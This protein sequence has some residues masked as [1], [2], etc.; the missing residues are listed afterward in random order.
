MGPIQPASLLQ[1]T[2]Y[3]MKSFVVVSCLIAQA[4][5][6]CFTPSNFDCRRVSGTFPD[7]RDCG[8][9]FVQCPN[10]Q[11]GSTGAA[12][13]CPPGQWFDPIV[14]NCN[15]GRP[16]CSAIRGGGGGSR[17]SRPRPQAQRPSFGGSSGGGSCGRCGVPGG[18]CRGIRDSRTAFCDP[19]NPFGFIQCD[20]NGR[21]VPQQCNGIAYNTNTC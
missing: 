8:Q 13:S 5:S 15:P 14:C 6:Q 12:I 1:R 2:A 11:G 4:F 17:P 9:S 7:P 10:P 19:N 3:K 21:A 18:S 20:G 16:N